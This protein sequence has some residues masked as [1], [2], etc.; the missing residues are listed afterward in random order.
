MKKNGEKEILSF[1]EAQVARVKSNLKNYVDVAYTTLESNYNA[2]TDNEYLEARYGAQLKNIIDI[3]EKIIIDAHS[4]IDSGELSDSEAKESALEQIKQLRY[5]NGKGYVWVNDTGSPFPKMIMHPTVPALDGTVM[6]ASKYNCALGQKENL[7]KAFV[8]VCRLRGEGFVDYM[9]PKPTSAGLT[10]DSKKLS[11]V[12]LVQGWDW[13]IGTGIY[14]DD[15]LSD[16]LEK[17]KRDIS[18]MRYDQG[19]GYFWINDMAQPVPRMVMHPIAPALDGQVLDNPKYNCANGKKENLFNAFAATCRTDKKGFVNYLWPKPNTQ[20]STEEQPKLSYVRLFEPMDWVIGT[21]IYLDDIDAMIAVR[22]EQI[23]ATTR[24]LFVKILAAAGVVSFIT[25]IG[26]LY[27]TKLFSAPIANC[28]EFAAKLGK[29]DFSNL[30]PIGCRDEV[31]QLSASLNSMTGEIT[32]TLRD[33]KHSSTFLIYASHKLH[34]GADAVANTSADMADQASL[35][36]SASEE[37]SVN[38][39]NVSDTTEMIA[40]DA[41]DIDE[42]SS[43]MATN[44][45]SMATATEELTASFQEVAQHCQLAQGLAGRVLENN[46]TSKVKMEALSLT[47]TEISNVINIITEITDQTKLL[48]LNATIEA[49]RAGEAGKG[50]AVV[51]SEVKELAKQT[52]EA[53]SDIFRQIHEMQTNTKSVETAINET[54]GINRQVDEINTTIAAAVEEQTATVAEIA[55]TV[56]GAAEHAGDVSSKIKVFTDR[57]EQDVVRA[58]K[59]ASLGVEEVAS[60]IQKVNDGAQKNRSA[61]AES[62]VYSDRIFQAAEQLKNDLSH[63]NI[64]AERFDIAAVKAA[65]FGWRARLEG[66]MFGGNMAPDDVTPHTQC[67]FGKWMQSEEGLAL[68]GDPTFQNVDALHEKVHSLARDVVQAMNV[69]KDAEKAESIVAEFEKTSSNL[70]ESLDKLYAG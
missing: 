29:G 58:V 10:E 31:G 35:V 22:K 27:F 65:H 40:T 17:S 15:A 37:I 44:I 3:A 18:K 49:A 4:K 53:T 23:Q 30:L 52:A 43:E 6:D 66:V 55:R 20:G 34:E 13:I 5:S 12:R 54:Y 60:N 68:R 56:A 51:A 59:E 67:D 48:A 14:V 70:A 57:I 50:F 7:F 36:A 45:Q 24:S 61:S 33:V 1:R 62:K 69:E 19:N 16:A 8:D 63:F 41:Q 42:S 38:I 64:G 47:A 28:N 2:A 25:F 46:E 9:W 21:G 11:Y 32:G 26:L 39:R